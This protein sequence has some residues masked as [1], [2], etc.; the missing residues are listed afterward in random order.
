MIQVFI[1]LIFEDLIYTHFIT[2]ELIARL[3][4]RPCIKLVDTKHCHRVCCQ[5]IVYEFISRVCQ[6]CKCNNYE[7]S[8]CFHIEVW[9]VGII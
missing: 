5:L 3:G 4:R 7:R 1:R 9:T 8:D 2:S 6:R